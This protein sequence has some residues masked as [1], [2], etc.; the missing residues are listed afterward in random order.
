M[1]LGQEVQRLL[2]PRPMRA[3]PQSLKESTEKWA[4]RPKDLDAD[5]MKE[6]AS[7]FL[8]ELQAGMHRRRRPSSGS[9]T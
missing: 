1:E 4:Q 6:Q 5:Q 7:A 9:R 2:E 8:S 3:S